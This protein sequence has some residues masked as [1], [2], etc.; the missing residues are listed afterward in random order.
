MLETNS[1]FKDF[2]EVN[3][4]NRYRLQDLSVLD[5]RV[6]DAQQKEFRKGKSKKLIDEMQNSPKAIL[7]K[8]TGTSLHDLSENLLN[9]MVTNNAF[10]NVEI[11]NPNKKLTIQPK[12]PNVIKSKEYTELGRSLME[13]GKEINKKQF[14]INSTGK[15]KILTENF[16]IDDSKSLGGSLDLTV[17][18]SDGSIGIFDYKFISF[19]TDKKGKV[20]E[21]TEINFKK[22]KSYSLQISEYKRILQEVYGVKKVRFTRIL[23][24]NVQYEFKN[25]KYT[26]NVKSLETFKTNKSYLMP[27]PVAKELGDNAYVNKV[28]SEL[29]KQQELL[30]ERVTSNYGT[31]LFTQSK[32]ELESLKASI[33][34][35]RS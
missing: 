26:G 10:K 16:V 1:K 27:L 11:G 24:S 3:G 31:D 32:N 9:Y 8:N 19:K 35:S 33:K 13:L 2:I 4:E 34:I 18:F 25:G 17:V 12:I 30:E 29:F 5:N 6:S 20:A 22:E 7:S 14:E 21:G 23:P 15:A 28:L